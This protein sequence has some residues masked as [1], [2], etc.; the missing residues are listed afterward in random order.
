[1][2]LTGHQTPINVVELVPESVARENVVLPLAVGE[3][4]LTLALRDPGDRHLID[5]LEFIHNR[6][7]VDVAAPA[8]QIAAAI[9]RHYGLADT[10]EVITA[11]FLGYDG[12]P[13]GP[14]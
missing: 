5:V 8:E 9:D 1:V 10:Q 3:G 13:S 12:G 11:C 6:P 14:E 2:D 4:G 7:I